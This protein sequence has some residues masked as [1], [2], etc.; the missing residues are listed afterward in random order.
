MCIEIHD[1][2]LKSFVELFNEF[3]EQVKL[4]F[5]TMMKGK[6]ILINHRNRNRKWLADQSPR[7]N[8]YN[9]PRQSTRNEISIRNARLKGTV[10]VWQLTIIGEELRFIRN[11]SFKIC[12]IAIIT[13][14]SRYKSFTFKSIKD[15]AEKLLIYELPDWSLS[16]CRKLFDS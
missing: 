11:S 16:S 15:R 8:Q 12:L 2:S 13:L 4:E 1:D 3:T 9:I 10:V 6:E 7:N 5:Q 14:K